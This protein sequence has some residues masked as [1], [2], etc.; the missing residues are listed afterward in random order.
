M[1]QCGL[2]VIVGVHRLQVFLQNSVY[3][4]EVGAEVDLRMVPFL[5][6]QLARLPE[7]LT[8]AGDCTDA[9]WAA[10]RRRD[11]RDVPKN[12]LSAAGAA[13]G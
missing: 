8:L 2:R 11:F 10:A 1:R 12:A 7:Q 6:H 3:A 4:A 5:P 13:P 9:L